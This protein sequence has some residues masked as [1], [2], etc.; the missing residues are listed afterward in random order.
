[1]NKFARCLICNQEF[2]KEDL[3]H[4]SSCPKCG[5]TGLP[6]D[7]KDDVVIKINW[8]E[9]RILTI[10]AENYAR[11]IKDDK[12]KPQLTIACIAR[13]IQK[14]YPDRTPLTLAGEIEQ[15]KKETDFKIIETNIDDKPNKI[16]GEFNA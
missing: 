6:A 4:A 5:N 10:W 2:T 11:S 8:H 1:M 9:L 3:K 14:Q 13:R 12:T 15:I 16:A 7:S